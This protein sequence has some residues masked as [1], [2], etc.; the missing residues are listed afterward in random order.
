MDLVAPV[1]HTSRNTVRSFFFF[2][3][4]VGLLL[5][6]SVVLGV[7]SETV[8]SKCIIDTDNQCWSIMIFSNIFN[9]FPT[10]TV[11]LR[12]RITDTNWFSSQYTTTGSLLLILRHASII[13]PFCGRCNYSSMTNSNGGLT[14]PLLS[15]GYGWLSISQF[16]L[17]I[18]FLINTRAYIRMMPI[19]SWYHRVLIENCIQG[20]ALG[21]C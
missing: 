21:I 19:R 2:N 11:W 18:I 12:L 7:Y 10:L 5:N 20:L 4:S 14:K 3:Y 13:T 9:S 16:F 6:L 1:D 8:Y 17:L 15:W